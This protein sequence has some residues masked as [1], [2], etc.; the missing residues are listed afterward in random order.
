MR[1]LNPCMLA[2]NTI[3][4]PSDWWEHCNFH[5][6]MLKPKGCAC[7]HVSWKRILVCPFLPCLNLEPFSRSSLPGR[8]ASNSPW[9]TKLLVRMDRALRN[10]RLHDAHLGQTGKQHH[11][12][13]YFNSSWFQDASWRHF[14]VNIRYL[15]LDWRRLYLLETIA[16][17]GK[18]PFSNK[19]KSS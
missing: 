1:P 16:H 19:Q 14:L 4:L 9:A 6:A 3:C 13:S 15:Y 5:C 2:C 17:R 12:S 18:A 7:S 8:V 10:L 11:I